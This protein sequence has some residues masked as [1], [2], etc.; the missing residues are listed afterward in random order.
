M[1]LTPLDKKTARL[2]FN[3][4]AA[5]Y[6]Q[7]AILE[8]EM[9][10]RLL[11]RIGYLRHPPERVLDIGCGTGSAS[12]TLKTQFEDATIISLDWSKAMLEVAGSGQP[13]LAGR[14]CADMHSLPLAA[15]SIDLVFSNLTLQWC[16]DLPAVFQEFRRVMS[17]GAMLVFNCYGPDTLREL[18]Q[19]WRSVDDYPHVHDFPDMHDI[20]DGLM[21]AGFAEPV[22]DIERLTMDYPDVMSL[23]RDLQGTGSRNAASHR[24]KGLTGRGRLKQMQQAYEDFSQN[25]RY[26]AS[27]EIT[28]GATFAPEEGQPVRSPD[29]DIA[30]FSVEAL[31][32]QGKVKG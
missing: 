10:S 13:S 32:S 29:G 23:L 8:Q 15:R 6:D 3:R 5:A 19:A 18:K 21:A 31:R 17:A 1:S 25:G 30:T 22:M 11:E 2:A 26:P 28:F 7:H 14:V 20:G 27:Y 9:E 12:R 24:F 16:V 4:A